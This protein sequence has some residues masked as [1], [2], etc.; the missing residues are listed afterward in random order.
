MLREQHLINPETCIRCNTCERRCPTGAI[1]HDE[2]NYVVNADICNFCMACVRPCPTGAVD[3]WFMLNRPYTVAEQ[4]GWHQLPPRVSKPPTILRPPT[5]LFRREAPAVATFV[6]SKRLTQEEEASEVRLIVIDF[7]DVAFP[8]L[9]GQC[10]GVV[11]PGKRSDSRPRGLR[12]YSIASARDGEEPG[13]STMAL[14]VKRVIGSRPDGSV[15]HGVASNWLCDLRP[16]DRI[17]VVGPFGE[18]F[19][20]PDDPEAELLMIG[21]GTGRAPFRGFLQRRLRTAPDA[22]GRQHMFFGTRTPQMFPTLDSLLS[23]PEFLPTKELTY[24]GAAGWEREYVQDR[25]RQRAGSLATM[26]RNDHLHIYICGSRGLE[27]DVD[28]ALAEIS[29]EH[30]IN[31][32]VLRQTLHSTGRYH[33]ETY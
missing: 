29:Q 2:R 8:F 4:L 28:V 19:L 23:N 7:G 18:T 26:L 9:E 15:F 3:N 5:Q 10:I 33:A 21:T 20:L 11:P 12:I 1:S 22:L 14:F 32:P 13:T 31:W 30:C 17:D 27:E 24:S 16:G 6:S 25:M